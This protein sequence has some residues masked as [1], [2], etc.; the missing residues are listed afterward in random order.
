MKNKLFLLTSAFVA[1]MALVGC[2]PTATPS[3]PDPDPVK[4]TVSG[5]SFT[6]TTDTT[7]TT[8]VYEWDNA[9]GTYYTT[10]GD[11]A[12]TANLLFVKIG[13]VDYINAKYIT[14][15]DNLSA[16][17]SGGSFI[18]GTPYTGPGSGSGIYEYWL[19]K[20]GTIKL[21]H[22]D[23]STLTWEEVEKNASAVSIKVAGID[24]YIW[25]AK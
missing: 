6:C 18:G 23:G 8:S 3:T 25:T 14:G 22:G 4:Q 19:Y 13:G 15:N 9:V 2:Q 20:D 11:V 10:T 24:T 7:K 1:I 5:I 16:P 17:T 12:V 21:S